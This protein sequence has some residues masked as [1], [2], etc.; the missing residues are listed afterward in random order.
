MTIQLQFIGGHN[1]T[2]KLIGYFS[3]GHL[4]HVDVVMPTGRLLG[5]RSDRCRGK[6]SLNAWDIPSGVRIRPPNYI[7]HPHALVRFDIP[8]T[9]DQERIFFDFLS[10]QIG[11]PYDYEAI[12][13]F[14]FSRDWRE[15]DSYICSELV[16]LALEKAKIVPCL[17][18]A[19]N[20]ITPVALALAV[21]AL[22]ST[23]KYG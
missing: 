22:G 11:R 18:L 5:A 20:K 9:P 1:F 17:Y 12:L 15:T 19:A 10:K 16:A 8:T 6:D 2:S 7:G 23:V 13:G 14:M 21:S 4:S 3:A